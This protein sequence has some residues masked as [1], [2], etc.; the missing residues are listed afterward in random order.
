MSANTPVID[1][2]VSHGADELLAWI[3]TLVLFA[4]HRE[5]LCANASHS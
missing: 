4:N 1:D 2:A 3:H 5:I